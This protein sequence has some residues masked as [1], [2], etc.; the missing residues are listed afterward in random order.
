MADRDPAGNRADSRWAHFCSV[1]MVAVRSTRTGRRATD[2]GPAL[3]RATGAGP[4][5]VR[6]GSRHTADGRANYS[7]GRSVAGWRCRRSIDCWPTAFVP[8]ERAVN[9]M[10]YR[11]TLSWS[12]VAR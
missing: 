9:W 3:R 1:W 10:S 7:T 11:K 2:L 12:P 6:P 4:D 8:E 5:V